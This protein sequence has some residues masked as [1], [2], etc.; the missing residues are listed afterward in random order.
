MTDFTDRLPSTVEQGALRRLSYATDVVTTDGGHEVRNARWATPLK[1]FEIS[2]PTS[3][4]DDDVYQAVV[5]LFEKTLGGL[6]T[7]L[8]KDWTD[9]S[10]SSLIRVRFDSPLEITGIDRRLD[11]IEK[12]TLM[13]VRT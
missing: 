1:T 3:R 10:G 7:F 13:E 5:F 11:H 9:E 2:F 12:L 6:H 4:R 8:F